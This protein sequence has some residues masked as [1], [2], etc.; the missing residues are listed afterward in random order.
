MAFGDGVVYGPNKDDPSPPPPPPPAAPPHTSSGS[1]VGGNPSGGGGSPNYG[2]PTTSEGQTFLQEEQAAA[3]ARG[4]GN[5][6]AGWT[7][8]KSMGGDFWSFF[9]LAET[10]AANTGWKH[11]LTPQQLVAGINAGINLQDQGAIFAW[12]AQTTGVDT[13]AMPWAATGMN[14]TQYQQATGT[15]SDTV[16]ELTGQG[17]WAKAGLDAGTLNKALMQG[18]S[19]QRIRDYIVSNPAASAQYGY[20]K[21]GQTGTYQ[22]FQD[23]KRNNAAEL[24]SRFGADYTDQNAIANLSD[25]LTAF[26]AQGSAFGQQTPFIAAPAA[27][28]EGFQSAIR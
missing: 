23:Y 5:P 9:Q 10:F 7:M 20:L 28:S 8:P 26:H 11:L 19:A 13:A 12:M 4:Q 2:I 17:D 16:F 24:S 25:P 1:S 15:L 22:A 3:A 18:W 21:F 14:S 6:F 27:A